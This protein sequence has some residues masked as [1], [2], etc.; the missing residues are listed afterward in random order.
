VVW[1]DSRRI[2]LAPRYSGY[3]RSL[4]VFAYRTI[5]FYGWLFHAILLTIRVTD[6]SPTTPVCIAPRF[7]LFPFRSPL[8]R[9]S[10]SFSFP[11]GTEMFH[12]P[13]FAPFGGKALPLPGYPIRKS[14]D[15]SKFPAPRGV[16]PV[17][18]SFIASLC[19]GIH[20]MHLISYRFSWIVISIVITLSFMI[21][22]YILNNKK[23]LAL[24]PII[25]VKL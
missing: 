24:F 3:F 19:Q 11:P 12:F 8:L 22:N 1:A 25:T 2:P 18:A 10:H 15:Q 9:E 4:H 16:S 14:T 6:G 23:L 21:R 17:I 20:H 5:T 13:G 7:G